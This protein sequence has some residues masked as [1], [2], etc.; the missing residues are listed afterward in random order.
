MNADV[1]TRKKWQRRAE[2][3]MMTE[4]ARVYGESQISL[5]KSCARQFRVHQHRDFGRDCSRSI[6][7]KWKKSR[8]CRIRSDSGAMNWTTFQRLCCAH[9]WPSLRTW[10]ALA[11]VS[12]PPLTYLRFRGIFGFFMR[13]KFGFWGI[14]SRNYL[15]CL[16]HH[17]SSRAGGRRLCGTWRPSCRESVGDRADRDELVGSGKCRRIAG[18]PWRPT[19]TASA[20]VSCVWNSNFCLLT[21]SDCSLAQQRKHL[22]TAK[23]KLVSKRE[24]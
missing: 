16:C 6:R 1:M 23:K 21:P 24:K 22:C 11:A 13:I 15:E 9:H 17:S 7:A 10:W 3:L 2:K 19:A 4:C 18:H 20:L 12:R 14:F 8:E 5:T